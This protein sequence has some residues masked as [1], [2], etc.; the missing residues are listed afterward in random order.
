MKLIYVTNKSP[1]RSR[2]WELSRIT[3]YNIGYLKY[4]DQWAYLNAVDADATF[5]ET[6]SHEIG[7]EILKYGGDSHIQKLI[8]GPQQFFKMLKKVHL[9]L[10]L[11]KLV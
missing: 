1:G 7:H 11:V 6:I 5:E 8:K 4:S 9:I 10:W 2:N 3:Y